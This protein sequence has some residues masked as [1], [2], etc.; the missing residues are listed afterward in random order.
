MERIPW[1]SN[2]LETTILSLFFSFIFVVETFLLWFCYVTETMKL[3]SIYCV[4][5]SVCFVSR[6]LFFRFIV[7]R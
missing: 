3:L 7:C 5:E 1:L 6:H 4:T 2:W